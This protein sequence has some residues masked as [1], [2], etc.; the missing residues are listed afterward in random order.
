MFYH[1]IN[2]FWFHHRTIVKNLLFYAGNLLLKLIAISSCKT[3]R[4]DSF[5]GESG[6]F[7]MFES[8]THSYMQLP[9]TARL[10]L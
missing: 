6:V 3:K 9:K 7:L 8:L 5:G 2:I 1:F 4:N 10:F